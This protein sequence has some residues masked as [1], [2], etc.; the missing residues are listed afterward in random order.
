[1]PRSTFFGNVSLRYAAIKPKRGS[2]GAC[3]TLSEVKTV[4]LEPSMW[5]LMFASRLVGFVASEGPGVEEDVG[6]IVHRRGAWLHI[7]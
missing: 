1:M 6:D 5:P 3:G 4:G 7:D 2:S